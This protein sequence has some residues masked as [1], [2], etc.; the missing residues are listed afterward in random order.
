MEKPTISEIDELKLIYFE[1]LEGFCSDKKTGYYI[2]HFTDNDSHLVLKKRSELFD[3]YQQEGVPH[4]TDLLKAAIANE[5]WSAAKEDKI[6]ELK[7]HI[8][9]NEKIIQGIIPEQRGNIEAIIQS[10]REELDELLF[11]RKHTLGR[12]IE[13]L[14]DDD[15]NDYVLYLSFHKDRE[16]KEKLNPTYE[17]FQKSHGKIIETLNTRLSVNYH[18]YFEDNLK[19]IS[20]LPIFL[21]KL[22]YSKDDMASFFGKPIIELSH[23]QCYILSLGL[24]NINVLQNSDGH[25]PD[26]N[27][28][29]KVS[30]LVQWYDIQHSIQIAK[31]KQQ[32]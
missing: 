31:K 5:E 19:K 21:N 22:S 23:H 17:D 7:Y 2:R 20:A 26:L 12:G 8:S 28:E 4:E 29:A 25:P 16:L 18:K 3:F 10:K 1:I 32:D 30:D 13:D 24:R 15:V 9:D 11:E 6:L 14:V 27:L